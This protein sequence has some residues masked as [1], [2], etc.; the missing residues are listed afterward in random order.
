MIGNILYQEP[1]Q[2]KPFK[3]RPVEKSKWIGNQDFLP[4]A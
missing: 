2:D 1:A 4:Y 3:F